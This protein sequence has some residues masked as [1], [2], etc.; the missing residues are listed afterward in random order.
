MLTTL[1]N[2]YITATADTHGAELHSLVSREGISYLWSADPR[3]W[4]YHAPTLFPNIGR[5]REDAAMSA[6]GPVHLPKHGIARTADWTLLEAEEASVCYQLESDEKTRAQYPFDF[7]LRL[8]YRLHGPSITTAYMVKNTGDK[9]MPFTIGGHPAFAV[10]MAEGDRFEDYAVS[11]AYPETA[12]LP[13]VD[14]TQGL[15][16]GSIRNR[17]LTNTKTFTLNHVLFRGDAL[18]FDRL[19]S[20]SLQ[21][22]SMRS[23]RGVQMDFEGMDY[24]AIWSP[25]QDAPFVCLEP[26]TGTATQREEDDVFEHKQGMRILAP[27]EETEV[28]F[29][30]TV[31]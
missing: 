27:G 24:L 14:M 1:K 30:V 12:D 11:F 10:P 20:R 7:Q 28:S 21:L 5:L 23:G 9:N 22:Y 8:T 15:I 13:Q 2:A 26:W 6:A 18:L 16:I 3:Y 29:T 31:F 17:F 25:D 4:G 19:R